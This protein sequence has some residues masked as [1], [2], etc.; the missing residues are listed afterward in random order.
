MSRLATSYFGAGL[1]NKA[2]KLR[3]QVLPISIRVRGAENPDTLD[4]LNA[5]ACSYF[6]DGRIAGARKLFIQTLDLRNKING[7][8]NPETLRAMVNL[9]YCYREAG[10]P[11]E[12]VNMA[13]QALKLLRIVNGAEHPMTL[14]AMNALADF[15][16]EAG[17]RDDAMKMQEELLTIRSKVLGPEHPATLD[18]MHNLA[19]SYADAGR[20]DEALGLRE[21][22]LALRIKLQSR[23]HPYTLSAMENLAESY[24]YAGRNTE[25]MAL[26]EESVRLDPKDT[27]SSLTLATEQSW[28]GQYGPYEATRC[29]LIQQAEETDQA[30]TADRAAKAY[31]LM[32]STN[33]ALLTNVLGLAQ[34]AVELGKADSYLPWFKMGLGMAEYR[35]GQYA[36]AEQ[37]L[38]IAEQTLG[39][40]HKEIKATARLFLAMSLFRQDRLEEARKLFTQ[41]EA[42]MPAF[43][44]DES[45]PFVEGKMAPRDVLI[46][47]LAYKEAKALIEGP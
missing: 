11:G 25:A 33:A 9:A 7:P 35:N 30:T 15:Y 23:E 12:A 1:R 18:A 19:T 14:D 32:P 28:F 43:P 38:T 17:R 2:L 26:L 40:D 22:V 10:Q 6:Y 46:S 13:E 5:L 21:R 34:R 29:R 47:W 16:N 24:N 36:A 42:Q 27:G 41:A 31:C 3:E 45:K 37:P 4:A 44:R 8:E 39:D 20:A